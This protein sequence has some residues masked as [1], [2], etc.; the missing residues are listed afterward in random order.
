M[1]YRELFHEVSANVMAYCEAHGI[2]YDIWNAEEAWFDPD[3]IVELGVPDW[4]EI[5]EGI[6]AVPS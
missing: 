5:P 3:S 6:Q 1:I 4:E 2:Q